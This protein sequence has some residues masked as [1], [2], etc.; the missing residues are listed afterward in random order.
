MKVSTEIDNNFGYEKITQLVDNI[1]LRHLFFE[2]TFNSQLLVLIKN[3]I[4]AL[5]NGIICL[6]FKNIVFQDIEIS[7]QKIKS[8]IL[9]IISLYCK[10]VW[11]NRNVKK[12]EKK[13]VNSNIVY[14]NFFI[15]IKI[16]NFGRF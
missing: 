4:F 12:F 10:T 7:N 13:N 8:V 5:S 16:E 15:S 11:L 1:P 14:L 2:C 3:W 6:D 9:L